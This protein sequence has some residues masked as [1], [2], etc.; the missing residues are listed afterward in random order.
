MKVLRSLQEL[1]GAPEVLVLN[2]QLP[3]AKSCEH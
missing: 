2:K 1:K 3:L